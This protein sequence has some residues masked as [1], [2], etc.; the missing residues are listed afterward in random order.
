MSLTWPCESGVHVLNEVVD[1]PDGQVLVTK[2][3]RR[4]V[5]TDY[6]TFEAVTAAVAQCC[7][8]EREFLE[9]VM[10]DVVHD[11]A[12]DCACRDCAGNDHILCDTCKRLWPDDEL[13][14]RG[15]KWECPDCEETRKADN[16]ARTEDAMDL[17]RRVR[18]ETW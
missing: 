12:N 3:E 14:H 8:C 1:C 13:T 9:A 2:V 10:V 5:E 18:M 7:C 4:T 15:S 6:V 16:E 11:G 17:A